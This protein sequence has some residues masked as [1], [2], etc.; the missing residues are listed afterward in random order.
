MPLKFSDEAFLTATYL[1]NRVP[2]PVIGYS[3][4][5]MKLFGYSNLH[6]GYKC[7]DID[8]GRLYISR[9]VVF[10]ETVFTFANLR[11]N[12]GA[13]L[14]SEIILLLSHLTNSHGD[15]NNSASHLTNVSTEPILPGISSSP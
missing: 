11:P 6:K 9:D 14:R 15:M 13:R 12:A 2:S 10:D 5:I 4:P 1:I 3:T 7:L 8:T